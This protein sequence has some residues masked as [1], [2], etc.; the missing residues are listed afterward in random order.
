[1]WVETGGA[2]L[3][4]YDPATDSFTHYRHN[5]ADPNS[6]PDDG[7]RA[8]YEDSAGGFW[9]GTVGGLCRFDRVKGICAATY[10]NDANDPT[11]LSDNDVRAIAVDRNTDLMWLG[12]RNH[13]V[14]ILDR[15]T[16]RFT[17]YPYDPKVPGSVSNG[18]VNSIYQDDAGTI[19]LSTR[20]GLDRFDPQTKSFTAYHPVAGDSHSLA[21]DYVAMAYQDRAGRFWIASNGGLARFDRTGGTFVNYHHDEGDPASLS[22]DLINTNALYQDPTGAIWIG[23]GYN[24]VSRL[25]GEA[26]KF[27]TIR[28]SPNNPNSL[29]SNVVTSL[30][31]DS[32]GNLWVGT[33]TGLDRF[34]GQTF[35]HYVNDSKDPTSISAGPSRHVVQDSQGTIW[36]GA[37]GGGL[38]RFDGDHFVG[39]RHDP[40]N[41]NSLGSDIVSS[42]VADKKAGV[43]I[44]LEGGGDDFFDGQTFTHYRT[45]KS[46]PSALPDAYSQ[47][48]FADTDGS[49]WFG[50]VSWGIA[51]F[52]PTTRTFADY[53]LDPALPGNQSANWVTAA[54]S[55]GASVWV[56]SITGL[57]QF[58]LATKAF[59]KHYTVDDGL[60]SNNIV[61][62]LSDGRGGLWISTDKGLSRFDVKSGSFRTYD[63]LDGLQGNDFSK[64]T[65]AIAPDGQ[66]AFGGVDGFST[67]YPDRLADNPDA[68]SVVLTDFQ[69]FNKSAPFGAKDSPLSRPINVA[70]DISLNYDQS[71]FRIE[72]A[73]L[74]F[75]TP[76]KNQYAYK[77][78]GFDKDWV[79][80]DSSH[81]TATYTNLNPGDYT[82]RVK[83]SNNDGVWNQQGIALK[84]SISPPWWE[85]LWFRLMLG[86]ALIALAFAAYQFRVRSLRQ[87]N[88]TL[89]GL[90]TART[91]DLAVAKEAAE[92]ANQAKTAFLANMSHELRSPL[93]A[94]LGQSERLLRLPSLTADV[95][96]SLVVMLRSG[97]HL[98]DL[99]NQVLDLSK[100]EAGA[101]TL[102]EVP[103]DIGSLA[104][105]LDD[106]FGYAA[107]TKNVRLTTDVAADVP[108]ALSGDVLKLRQVLI[109]LLGNAVKFTPSGEVALRVT[110][111]QSDAESGATVD[112]SATARCRL[113]FSIEDTGVGIGE[114]ELP[115]IF[116]TFTQAQAGRQSR[117]GTGLGLT[118]SKTYVELMGGKLDIQSEMNHGTKVAFEL[119][120]AIAALAPSPAVEMPYQ[121]ALAPGQREF[122]V[123]VADDDAP[124]RDTYVTV[125]RSIGMIVSEAADGK[126]ATEKATESPD[127]IFMDVRMPVMD[128]VEATRTIRSLDGPQ[129]VIV[130]MTA[131]VFMDQAPEILAAGCDDFLSK[132]FP[133][134]KL[135]AIIESHLGAKFVPVETGQPPSASEL[136]AARKLPAELRDEL[137][138]AIDALEVEAIDAAI[139]RI[140]DLDSE[141]GETLADY[142]REFRYRAI[143]RLVRPPKAD[144]AA[145]APN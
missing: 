31:Y 112:D 44:G 7:I 61:G 108:R 88:R 43:W 134:S 32:A 8:L 118:I 25:A 34:D 41:G 95:R 120:F 37:Y 144:A 137:A 71:V 26:A 104:S 22:N 53:L 130:A 87:R 141:L 21:N 92:A 97:S 101:V 29:G 89:E 38:S 28:N 107:S 3:D 27:A 4:R 24:G 86:L 75:S 125:L 138:N 128:G 136:S 135:V 42:L 70:T 133:L 63:A 99:V 59:T 64:V 113:L 100:V 77:L 82:F 65:H 69:V 9:V 51:R 78:D 57:F 39:Y 111:A 15:A 145:D 124:S 62:V 45:V 121:V 36:C 126:E 54:S 114:E 30:K 76:D 16:G 123:L 73:A 110:R 96:S 13:G 20:G 142:A 131:S 72:F 90:V 109:N 117:E 115:S 68:P 143:L 66:L 40:N 83:A 84:I 105:E 81:R 35:Q 49:V 139:A 6:L 116:D 119:P 5:A 106:M 50:T 129:P 85:M 91:H 58:D 60:P 140:R 18:A 14:S 46:D 2:G 48:L 98:R 103:F 52:N 11:S 102:Q 79:Y 127:L 17:Q 122:H 94:I 19:W 56:G 1:M 10:R 23:T 12:T 55:D 74:G 132:P 33:G 80:T 67:F 93:T 47:P